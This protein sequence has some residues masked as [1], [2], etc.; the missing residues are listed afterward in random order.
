V[1]WIVLLIPGGR[2]PHR[3]ATHKLVEL[4]RLPG[5]ELSLTDEGRLTHLISGAL[6]WMVTQM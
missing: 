3:L 5:P 2:T 6:D 4:P 1:L